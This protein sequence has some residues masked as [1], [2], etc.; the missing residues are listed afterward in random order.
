MGV[1]CQRTQTKMVITDTPVFNSSLIICFQYDVIELTRLNM[2]TN[3]SGCKCSVCRAAVVRT[4][5]IIE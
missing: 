5:Y 3:Q 1:D 4:S 2:S